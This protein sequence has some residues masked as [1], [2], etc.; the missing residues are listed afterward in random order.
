MS[1]RNQR[2]FTIIELLLFLAITGALFV[3]L[4]VG[5]NSNIVQQ[6]YR[7]SV[8]AYTSLLQQQYSD[9]ANTRNDRGDDW[10]CSDSVVE[11]SDTAGE[12]R[13]TT[14]CVIMGRYV[15]AVDGGT[16]VR[17]GSIIGSRPDNADTLLSDTQTVL[18]YDPRVSPV[19]S[20]V[21]DITWGSRLVK[22]ETDNV[23]ST[24]S[25]VIIRSPLSGL[26]RVYNSEDELPATLTNM[27]HEDSARLKIKACVASSDLM[28][29]P[30]YSVEVNP[31]IAGPNGVITNVGDDRC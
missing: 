31:N 18:A 30:R 22:P 23:P 7:D 17:V 2:G 26:I 11:Q 20:A 19:D 5:V 4:M 12:F 1:I 13:G 9:V 14:S 6:Q 27:I 24:M 3:A 28:T 25:F 15:Q 10:T 21:Q 29:G 8:V 16:K